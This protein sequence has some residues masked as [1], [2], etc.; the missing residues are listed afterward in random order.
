MR[1][2]LVRLEA[3]VVGVLVRRAVGTSLNMIDPRPASHPSR[4][5]PKTNDLS[6]VDV[7]R[8]TRGREEEQCVTMRRRDQ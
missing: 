6:R 7:W 5:V 4:T 3:A 1:V 8:K 2:A